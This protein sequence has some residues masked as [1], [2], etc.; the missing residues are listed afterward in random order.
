MQQYLFPSPYGEKVS[1][2]K[3]TRISFITSTEYLKFPS[4]YGEKVSERP[5]QRDPFHLWG[6]SISLRGKG[7]RKEL[8]QPFVNAVQEMFPSPCG[9]KV[10]ESGS[11][12]VFLKVP[13]CVVSIPLRGKGLRKGSPP[14][15]DLDFKFCFHPLT[16]KRFEKEKNVRYSLY[17][18]FWFPSP[19][20]EKV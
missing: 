17:A 10:C 16:G 20:G 12:P 3:N 1:E 2:I 9:E 19:C 4:P 13:V 14:N 18:G 15:P 6:V 11:I 8:I 7:F 5:S